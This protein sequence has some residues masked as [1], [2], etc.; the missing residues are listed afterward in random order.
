MRTGPSERSG[1]SQ[2]PSVPS[3]RG[4]RGVPSPTPL[5]PYSR[6]G[7]GHFSGFGP[8]FALIPSQDRLRRPQE[9]PRPPT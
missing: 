8:L 6:S 7:L 4:V 9:W 5:G 1:P 2:L 3:V